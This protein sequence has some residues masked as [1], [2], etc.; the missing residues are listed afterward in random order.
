VKAGDPVA[1]IIS[2]AV[3][4]TVAWRHA[5][6]FI[7]AR[8]GIA[9]WQHPKPIALTPETEGTLWA[10]GHEGPAVNALHVVATFEGK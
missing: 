5:T 2:G 8:L 4:H 7:A 3:R 9:M 10:Y 6:Y 1:V